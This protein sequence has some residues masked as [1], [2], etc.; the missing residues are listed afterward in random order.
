MSEH[1]VNALK[2]KVGAILGVVAYITLL[3]GINFYQKD[4][5]VSNMNDEINLKLVEYMENHRFQAIEPRI[6]SVWGFVPGLKGQKLIM[7]CLIII[8]Y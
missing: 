1:E 3:I 8:C 5:P 6:D 2:Q 4:Y 7:S